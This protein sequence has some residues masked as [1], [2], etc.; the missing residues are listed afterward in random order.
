[1]RA[2]QTLQIYLDLLLVNVIA[3][4]FE[5]DDTRVRQY[6]GRPVSQHGT[7]SCIPNVIILNHFQTF[8]SSLEE[9]QK[10]CRLYIDTIGDLLQRH[11][12]NMDVY[13]VCNHTSSPFLL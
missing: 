7:P 11:M 1:M 5:R 12:A 10:E 3:T 13:T 2:L 4:E 9:K 8:L 6:T